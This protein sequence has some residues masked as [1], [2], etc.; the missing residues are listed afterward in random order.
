MAIKLQ[1]QKHSFDRLFFGLTVLFVFF[2]I[3]VIADASAPLAAKNF[4][5]KFYF[6]KQQLIPASIGLLISL[7][8][9]NI[10][11]LFWEKVATFLF[12]GNIILM[13]MVFLPGVGVKL[14]GASR[15]VDLGFTLI[16]PSE[17]LKLTISMYL[18]K[19]ASKNMKVMAFFV[20]FVIS[21]SLIMLQ[22][23][24]GTALVIS[25]I[26]MIQI[27]VSGVS[28]VPI[29]LAGIAGTII[30]TLLITFS[31]YRRARLEAFLA[32]TTNP[33][34]GSYHIKQILLALGS[35]GIMGVGLGQSMQKY[36]FL[37]ETATDSIFAILAEE[38]GFVGSFIVLSIFALLIYRGFKIIL[39]APDIFSKVLATGI[40]SWISIQIFLNVGSMV[41]LIPL[42][43]VPLPF[44]SYGGSALISLLIAC[45]ILLN[46]SKNT[47]KTYEK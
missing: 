17:F 14:Q 40:V 32:Q 19:V 18:A 23:D 38:V 33:L 22:P 44:V 47:K 34:E 10:N 16:Q 24:L 3:V 30:G 27:F 5:D 29:T 35:G 31:D 46:I 41:A 7:I 8:V 36:L 1:K 20:P 9:M 4:N 13:I 12:F 28:M 39:E 37:P 25:G 45:G 26:S 2:G 42:T 11:Y 21:V 15:W 6:A 43:G